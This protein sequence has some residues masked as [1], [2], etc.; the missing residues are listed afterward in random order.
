M[1]K[2]PLYKLALRLAQILPVSYS[3]RLGMFVGSISYYL[4]PSRRAQ[5]QKNLSIVLGR[6]EVRSEVKEVFQN[7]GRYLAEFLLPLDRRLQLL[8]SAEKAGIEHMSHSYQKGKGVLGLTAHLG[9]WEMA[10]LMTTQLGC[11]VRAIFLTHPNHQIDEL[12]LRQRCVK[13]LSVI[14]W[15]ENSLKEC[16]AAL[17]LGHLV[18]IAGDIDFAGT[19]FEVNLFGRKTK[20]PR[21]P[22]VLA[23]RMGCPIVFG[24]YAWAD[25]GSRVF[26]E[27]PIL[28]Q[29]LSDQELALKIAGI[30]E[31]WIR[32]YP[33]QWFCFEDIWKN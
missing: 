5:L 22:L 1:W 31:K 15:K 18:A 10:A 9:N 12:F 8:A 27:E 23:R 21:G 3:I 33:T 13:D 4:N 17:R 16:L 7:F 2:Y 20:I 29:G 14:L 19:G 11:R 6:E 32:Q 30:L 24:G 26:Y 28:T 25:S